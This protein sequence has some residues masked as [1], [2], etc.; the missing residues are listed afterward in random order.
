MAPRNVAGFLN[1]RPGVAGG[2]IVI[3]G[4]LDM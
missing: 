2:S 4:L 3:A 1:G